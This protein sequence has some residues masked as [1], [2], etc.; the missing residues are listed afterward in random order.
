MSIYTPRGLKLS[1]DFPYAF[2]LMARLQPQV[3]PFRILRTTEGI[4]SLP[5]MF[6]FIAGITSFAIHLPPFQIALV[7]AAS[8]MAGTL[9]S[10][11]SLSIVPG[12]VRLGTL[13]SYASG[14][15]IYLIVTIIAGF[16]LGGWQAVAAFFV[17]KIIASAGGHL[18]EFWQTSRY[19]KLTGHPF[20]R[21]EVSF[22]NAYR[23]HASRIYVTTD[24]DLS[25]DELKEDHWGDIFQRFAMEWPEAVQGFTTNRKIS[26]QG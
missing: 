6:A 22:F 23:F 12:L 16:V 2:G 10:A 9:I 20:T 18:L 17:G 5:G 15:G 24:I 11:V 7:V 19:Y 25:D 1:I 13:Y 8:Q 21:S 3:T 4:E 14:Y 26:E